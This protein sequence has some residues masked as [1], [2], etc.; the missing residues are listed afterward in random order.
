MKIS[1]KMFEQ[2]IREELQIV[3][4][5]MVKEIEGDPENETQAVAKGIS[6]IT[7]SLEKIAEDLPQ[8]NG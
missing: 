4:K 6:D 1:K 3:L 8:D 5:S 2:F 7:K